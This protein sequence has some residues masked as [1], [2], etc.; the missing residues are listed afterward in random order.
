MGVYAC[1]LIG[2]KRLYFSYVIHYI[3]AILLAPFLYGKK[4]QERPGNQN[5]KDSGCSC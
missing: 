5:K 1:V 3:G 4:N 2:Q